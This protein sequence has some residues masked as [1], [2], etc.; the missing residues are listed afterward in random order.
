MAALKIGQG[1]NIRHK[2]I[3]LAGFILLM[4]LHV[5]C[6]YLFPGRKRKIDSLLRNT[7]DTSIQIK[8]KRNNVYLYKVS[9]AVLQTLKE[10]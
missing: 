5:V 6:T 10:Y 8:S 7:Y 2:K 1:N 9:D 3:I 4:L